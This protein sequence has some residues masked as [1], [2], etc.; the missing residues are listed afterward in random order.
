MHGMPEPVR[1]R[2][3]RA[4]KYLEQRG[5]IQLIKKNDDLFLKLTKKGKTKILLH[6]LEQSFEK[7]NSW[8]GK[9]RLIIWD[10]PESSNLERD[11]IRRVIKNLG[12]Y[13]L[14]H[15]VFI[16]PYPWPA[17]A[18]EYLNE[19]GLLKFIRFIRADKLDDEGALK[20]HFGL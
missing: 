16:T 17:P 10:I 11:K 3:N 8:D 2:Y 15:S 13:R 4:I 1:W 19:S 9:W 6:R 14:Q 20:K 18:V 12:C 7:P 5:Q